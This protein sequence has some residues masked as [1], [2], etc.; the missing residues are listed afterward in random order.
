M[1]GDDMKYRLIKIALLILF[2]GSV[3]LD[4][5][6]EEEWITPSLTYDSSTGNYIIKYGPVSSPVTLIYEL[7]NKINP[8]V[9]TSIESIGEGIYQYRYKL[10]NGNDS[11]QK[12]QSFEIRYWSVPIRSE[13]PDKGWYSR[14]LATEPT[15][16]WDDTKYQRFGISPGASLEGFSLTA[17]GLPG[18]VNAYFQGYVEDV[19]F[20]YEPPDEIED[21][22]TEI[23]LNV[24]K[25]YVSRKTLGPTAPPADFKAI[26]FLNYI[27]SMKHEAFSLGWITSYGIEQSLD[28]K[29]DNAKKKIEQGNKNA[30]KN[31][32]GAFINEV[33]AQRDKH[34]TSEAYGLLKYNVQYLIGKL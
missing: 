30:A 17:P 27:I 13:A 11:L 26:D 9:N 2:M 21:P 16:R 28:A 4:S 34:L 33:E 6:K 23:D 14:S 22:L 10:Y 7:P 1:R 25:S 5:I 8:S 32:L 18:I 15:W 19:V 29:L 31:I 24:E 20:P 12:L 3:T